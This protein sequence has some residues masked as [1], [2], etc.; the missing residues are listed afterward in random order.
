MWIRIN[1]KSSVNQ[2]TYKASPALTSA[3]ESRRIAS[4]KTVV[5]QVIL[6]CAPATVFLYDKQLF[7]AVLSFHGLLAILGLYYALRQQ[8]LHVTALMLGCVPMLMLL[9]PV[10]YQNS[11]SV[12]FAALLVLWSISK[13]AEIRRL[14]QDRLVFSMCLFA[15]GY[16]WFS[17]LVTGSYATNLRVFELTFGAAIVRLLSRSRGFL[18]AALWGVGVSTMLIVI[19]ISPYGKDRL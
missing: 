11:I 4:P 2:H 18:S 13:P 3:E 1:L 8:T 9:R 12:L 16:W 19:G 17:V 10:F 5:R 14:I 15:F 7:L 6:C